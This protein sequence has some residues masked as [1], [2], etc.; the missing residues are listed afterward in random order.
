MSQAADEPRDTT[1]D[2]DERTGETGAPFVPADFTI[3][4]GFSDGKIHLV[5]LGPEHNDRDYRAWTSSMD[6]IQRTPGF[7]RYGWP[8][9]MT[10]EDNLRDL[11]RHREDFEHRIGFTYSVLI[12]EDVIGCVY[13]YP[14]GPPGHAVVRSWVREDH[15]ELDER[16]YELVSEWLRQKWPF[17]G[18]TYSPRTEK[19]DFAAR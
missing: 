2:G 12:D 3:P 7:E 1:H 8:V 4:R 11:R 16:L 18:F 9:P 10:R 14:A 6:H 19:R 15:A 17:R 5:P 13:I